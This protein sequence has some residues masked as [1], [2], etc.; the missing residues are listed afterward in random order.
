MR[1]EPL[2]IV[3]LGRHG[4]EGDRRLA[5]RRIDQ[6]GGAPWLTASKVPEK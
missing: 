2:N 6:R 3:T 4:L 1:G 5:F